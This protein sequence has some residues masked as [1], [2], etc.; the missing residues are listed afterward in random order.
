M[1]DEPHS[2]QAGHA[3]GDQPAI[4]P[5]YRVVILSGL[6]P[7][8]IVQ[9]ASRLTRDV[10][11]L[12]VAGV[13]CDLPVYKTFP[14]RVRSFAANV[15]RPEFWPYVGARVFDGIA[16]G[17]ARCGHGLLRLAHG[18]A[19]LPALATE[20]SVEWMTDRVRDLGGTV[21]TTTAIHAPESL[22]FVRGLAPDLG[23]VYGTRIL[24]P[25][26]FD[27]PRDGSINVHKRRVPDYRGGGPI[28]LWELLDE[29]TEI[30][31]TV[32]RVSAQL[33]A[34]HVIRSDTI[35][36]EPYDSLRSLELKA[37]VVG[38]DL[39][40]AV[41]RDFVS[42]TVTE[43]PQP[44]GG[45]LFRTPSPER[46]R[47]YRRVIDA[48]RPRFRATRTRP[49]WKLLAH[50]LVLGP[51]AVARNWSSRRRSAFPV[52]VLYHH[53]ITDRP[54][55]L[56]LPT[57]EYLRHVEY[58]SRHY[59][60]VSLDEAVVLLRSG[61]VDRPTVVLT[62]DDGYADNVVNARAVADAAPF[63]AT[64]FV[65]SQHV[66]SG[67]PFRHDETSGHA[68]FPPMT[69]EGVRTLR[70]AGFDVG[71]HTRSHFDCGSADLE[72]LKREIVESRADIE[73]QLGAPVTT[74]SFPWGRAANMSEAAVRLALQHY[75]VV[76]SAC[77]GIN[78]PGL[79]GSAVHLRRC[80]HPG[81]LLEL[82]MT[83]QSLLEV[84]PESDRL[85]F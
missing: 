43:S 78:R 15:R 47:G 4:P 79:P 7:R 2:P 64:F 32:H 67:R 41:A 40:V 1:E 54:H 80:V 22:A 31:I 63:P 8:A 25:S 72:T 85:S 74:F 27:I 29:R 68:G 57:A 65:S 62:F 39:L 77:N 50:V 70:R 21:H 10:P 17:L 9:L 84:E 82:E 52:V 59:R 66:E 23:I 46:L 37:N 83:L 34:G 44:S 18:G 38:E 30:G 14:Q 61:V 16:S 45:R 26:L 53:L 36:I 81:T 33:D 75:D 60:I 20:D 13:L 19:Q 24:K 49:L 5:G 42:G 28:G 58:L 56:G 76:L 3:D 11:G 12:R 71:S 55:P 73:A 48:R 51:R 69:W 6:P 35:P